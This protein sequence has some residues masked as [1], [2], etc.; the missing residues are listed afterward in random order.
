MNGYIGFKWN[1][2]VV[3]KWSANFAAHLETAKPVFKSSM[4]E[5]AKLQ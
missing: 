1:G 3:F 2:L 4:L 5:I